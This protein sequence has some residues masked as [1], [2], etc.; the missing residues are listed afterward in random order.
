VDLKHFEQHVLKCKP[1]PSPRLSR[2]CGESLFPFGF[3][4]RYA[5]SLRLIGW[6]GLVGALPRYAY[7]IDPQS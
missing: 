6:R 3:R 7:I 5:V 2:L 4:L 1:L